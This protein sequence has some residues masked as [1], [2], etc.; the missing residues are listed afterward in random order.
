MLSFQQGTN[1]LRGI[2]MAGTRKPSEMQGTAEMQH[3][4]FSAITEG[5]EAL[6]VAQGGCGC[7][8]SGGIEGQA[9]CGSGQPGLL[10]GD[11]AHSRGLKQDDL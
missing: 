7:S 8:I 5:G 11:P 4:S 10:V 1:S 3:L 9:G 6:Q 2:P